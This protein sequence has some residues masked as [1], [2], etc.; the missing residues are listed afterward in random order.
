[1]KSENNV[2]SFSSEYIKLDSFLKLCCACGSG[3]EAKTAILDGMV[4][5]NGS[6]CTERGK[7]VRN[8]DIIGFN[9]VKYT[10]NREE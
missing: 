4:S 2:V 6:I 1:M 8:G 9:G 10:A 3:G 5:I 7:K